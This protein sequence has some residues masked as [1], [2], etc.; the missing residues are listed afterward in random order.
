MFIKKNKRARQRSSPA[1][2]VSLDFKYD[3][4]NNKDEVSYA[5]FVNDPSI[6]SRLVVDNSGLLQKLVWNDGDLQWKEFWSAPKYRCDKYAQCGAF[7]KCGPESPDNANWF[8]CACLPGY[9]PKSPRD[10]SLR[11]GSEGCVRKESMCGNGEGFVMMK[12][13]KGPDSSNAAWMD[14]SMSSSECKQACLSNCSCTAFIS[15]NIDGMGTRCLA[16]YG[17]LMDVVENTYEWWDLNVRVDA[18]EL[19]TYTSKSEG[20]LGH[21]RQVAIA[22]SAV[23]VPL[24]LVSFI[25]YMCQMK[26]RKTKRNDPINDS[27]GV[28]SIN[29][30]GNLVLHDSFNC[31]LWSTNVSFQVTA[32]CVAQLQDSR[33][34]VLI[35]G[36]NKKWTGK[37]FFLA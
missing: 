26:K 36:N 35:Q 23:V 19:A 10:W 31:L 9:E 3:F 13:L 28:L 25:A 37:Q 30:F 33:N 11:D 18:T 32:S 8:E 6:I 7:S 27:A 17:E 16:W 22:I 21:K 4:V 15:M 1:A 34:L 29:Q 2:I 24:F 5:Y 20:F 14:M 12:R